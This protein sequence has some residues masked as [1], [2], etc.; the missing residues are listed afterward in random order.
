MLLSS[1]F[2]SPLIHVAA[3]LFEV[4]INMNPGGEAHNG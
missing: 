1:S 4:T 3:P 2:T